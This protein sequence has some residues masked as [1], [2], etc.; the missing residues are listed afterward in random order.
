MDLL[1]SPPWLCWRLLLHA[2]SVA[3]AIKCAAL[4]GKCP[5][6]P[7]FKPPSLPAELRISCTHLRP[8][9]WMQMTVAWIRL[10]TADCR[11][12][13][14]ALD[15]IGEVLVDSYDSGTVVVV[16]G[17]GMSSVTLLVVDVSVVALS[18]P[19]LVMRVARCTC[20]LYW[21]NGA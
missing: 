15:H 1:V 5:R 4:E 13:T 12:Q 20:Q 14:V 8:V 16:D 10:Q 18:P 19:A 17:V 7:P 11:L 9:S 6:P 21:L 3:F 2:A